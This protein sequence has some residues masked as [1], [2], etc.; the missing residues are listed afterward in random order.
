M[1]IFARRLLLAGCMIPD[2]ENYEAT[3]EVHIPQ[4]CA[5]PAHFAPGCLFPGALNY[6]PGAREVGFCRYPTRGCT[7]PNSINY[8]S[9]ATENDGSCIAGVHGCSLP[10]SD[11]TGDVV[12]GGSG[13]SRSSAISSSGTNRFEADSIV[14][15]GRPGGWVPRTVGVPLRGLVSFPSYGAV[16]TN[17][18][19]ANLLEGCVVAIEGCMDSD[20]ANF[21]P[22]ATVN[23]GTWCVPYLRGCMDPSAVNYDAAAT[24]NNA[25]SS[26]ASDPNSTSF[27]V[28]E[29]RGCLSPSALNFDPLARHPG[30]CY[31]SIAGCL[32][33]GA[34]NFRCGYEGSHLI[35]A[36]TLNSTNSLVTNAGT[37]GTGLITVHEPLVCNLHISV[38]DAL[39]SLV[40]EQIGARNEAALRAGGATVSLAPNL[41]MDFVA[42]ADIS[43]ITEATIEAMQ[44][45]FTTL[46]P[47]RRADRTGVAYGAGSVVFYVYFM[48][49]NTGELRT[50]QATLAPH[51]ASV[52]A[53]DSFLVGT[54]APRVLTLPRFNVSWLASPPAQ[55]PATPLT[56]SATVGISVGAV[57]LAV[58][59][60]LVLGVTC[61]HRSKQYKLSQVTPAAMSP[62][63]VVRSPPGM[64]QPVELAGGQV[65][66]QFESPQKVPPPSSLQ[67]ELSWRAPSPRTLAA[68]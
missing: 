55:E 65:R 37:A 38:V 47:G 68:A 10:S 51:T 49:A 64:I 40:D 8:H 20:A 5:I 53:L 63:R 13:E 59:A 56:L 46:H 17:D 2:D 26:M 14:V 19:S 29:R 42:D 36:C 3:A 39:Q 6:D 22:N 43:D 16:V 50:M 7:E 30:P 15:R 33:P 24:V 35:T 4:A 61:L 48:L 11:V 45:R 52:S 1:A 57:T 67:M 25:P 23:S 34:L 60:G 41:R 62:G 44:E 12:E 28:V 54:G 27:C 66:P 58:C 31:A 18:P 9:L 32:D 21:D